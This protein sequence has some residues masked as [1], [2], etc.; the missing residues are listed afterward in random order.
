MSGSA[1]SA[2]TTDR[3]GAREAPER[4]DEPSKGTT[5]PSGQEPSDPGPIAP[6]GGRLVDR[7]L[8]ADET[9]AAR[10]AARTLPALPL[11]ERSLSDLFLISVGALSPLEGFLDGPAYET[12]VEEMRL[13]SGLPWSVPVVLPVPE[14]EAG[15]LS[16][17][18][19]VALLAPDGEPAATL[20]L[21]DLFRR[22]L[23]REAERV[24]GTTER[25]H[26]GVA[27]LYEQGP[28][29]AAGPVRWFHA[30]DISGFPEEHLTPRETRRRF[31][32]LG[33]RSVVAFQTRNPIHRAHEYIQKCALEMV[34]GLLL[35]PIVGATKDDDVP[36]EIRMECYRVILERYFPAERVLLA[37]LPAAMRY[38]GPREAVHHAIMRRN[39]GCT[40]FI[41]G[42]DHAGV[43]SYYGTYDAQRIFDRVDREA[44]GIEPLAFEHAFW[45]RLTRQ[46]AT[47]KSSPAPP[48]QRLFLSGTRVREMLARGERPPEEF[49]RPE[50]AEILM[51]A[52]RGP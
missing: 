30:H 3:T 44:L 38:A 2:E 13:P 22:D 41:V 9:K 39:Y 11:D 29:C 19:R 46:M 26:P 43:G 50:V 23:D 40:H 33:W 24:Y 37:V 28:A 7:T 45:C 34:D 36:A 49:T 1:L 35:H 27:A 25:A 4:E 51:R 5:G 16:P 52:Y 12:V 42:R 47:S 6:Y 18:D 32:R 14:A 10:E 21:M 15:R 17:G 8:S 31:D 48:E 20:E